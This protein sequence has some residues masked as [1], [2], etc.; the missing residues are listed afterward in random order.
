MCKGMNDTKSKNERLLNRLN[1]IVD[2]ETFTIIVSEFAGERIYFPS[3]PYDLQDR[4]RA[5]RT[6]YYSGG[7]SI[8]E[9]SCKYYLSYSQIRRIVNQW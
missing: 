9:L 1:S 8:E 5:I 3:G 6:D 7:M 4:N 2:D